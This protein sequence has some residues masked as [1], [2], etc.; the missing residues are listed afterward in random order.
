MLRSDAGW[1][2]AGAA[3][4]RASA[5]AAGAGAPGGESGSRRSRTRS[6]GRLT[7]EAPR[8]GRLGLMRRRV[9]GAPAGKL[10]GSPATRQSVFPLWTLYPNRP[11][12][13]EKLGA[14]PLQDGK[15][16]RGA[17]RWRGAGERRQ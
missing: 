7:T 3:Q 4:A 6:G 10:E 11:E 13:P 17:E 2:R 9:V 14:L 5:T 12:R 16:L 1:D 8:M 15:R